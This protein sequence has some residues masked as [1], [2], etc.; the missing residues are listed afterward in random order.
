MRASMHISVHHISVP[1][2]LCFFAFAFS[3]SFARPHT[4]RGCASP[5]ARLGRL[6]TP[7][8]IL[9]SLR[10]MSERFGPLRCERASA[11]LGRTDWIR[12]RRQREVA[13]VVNGF[14]II[15]SLRGPGGEGLRL[16]GLC[17]HD[18][19]SLDGDVQ[20]CKASYAVLGQ[21]LDQSRDVFVLPSAH[22]FTRPHSPALHDSSTFTLP[23]P[24]LHSLS[25][26]SHCATARNALDIDS[27]KNT[28]SAS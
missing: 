26:P 25:F 3:S 20:M 10:G 14:R 9:A 27:P 16:A 13:I 6:G 12:G 18:C 22:S 19:A 11:W 24:I 17:L 21:P 8:C 23:T 15:A 2:R 1:Y 5:I 4:S 28:P 7:S